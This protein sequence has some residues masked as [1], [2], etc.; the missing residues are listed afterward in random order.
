MAHWGRVLKEE[1]ALKKTI[2]FDGE[3]AG[4]IV[5]F[6]NS[7]EREVG[8]WIGRGFWGRGVA[9]RALA[10]F[11]RLEERRPLH[12]RVVRHNTASIR[13]LEKCGFRVTGEEDDE[14]VLELGSEG[15]AP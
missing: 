15:T 5:S 1:T 6:V 13:V 14:I 8:Y 4:N 3:V 12:A 7:G 10:E 9:T 2:L 11:L